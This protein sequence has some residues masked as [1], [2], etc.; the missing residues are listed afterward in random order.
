MSPAGAIHRVEDDAEVDEVRRQIAESSL[1][2]VV[3]VAS[4]APKC[5]SLLTDVASLLGEE[6]DPAASSSSS[7]SPPPP[8]VLVVTTDESDELEELAIDLGLK[9]VPSYQIYGSGGRLITASEEGGTVTIDAIRGGLRMAAA[10]SSGV[11]GSGAGGGGGCCPPG[12]NPAVCCPSGSATDAAPSNPND[13]RRL[14]QQSYAATVNNESG[15]CCVSVDPAAVG[16]TPEQ[17][18]KAGKDANLG[19]GC[20]NPMSFAN[21]AKGETVLDLG[22]GAGVD[23]FLAADEVKKEGLV[24]GVDMTPDMI[25]KARSNAATRKTKNVEFRLGEIEYLPVADNTVDCVVSNCVI[26]LSPDKP[27]VFREIHRILKKGGRIAVSDVVIRPQKI[28]PDHLKTAEALAL[29]VTG[30]PETERLEQHL[31]DAGFTEVNVKLKEESRA[32]IS[33]WLPGSG[34]EDYVIGAEITA[35]K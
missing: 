16:Y 30:A 17:I 5:K 14:V 22:S 28:I 7:S 12:A 32:V 33:Q 11:N 35:R 25:H 19:L 21:V 6:E 1:T 34:A 2:L 3:A 8:L 24:I 26:N 4:F 10:L 9:D 29:L 18:L 31:I 20:G 27:Q 13:V 23:C 15:G